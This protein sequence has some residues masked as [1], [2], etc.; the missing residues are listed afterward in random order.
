MLAVHITLYI[1]SMILNRGA[2]L[3]YIRFLKITSVFQG[4]RKALYTYVHVINYVV[5]INARR[6]HK[7]NEHSSSSGTDVVGP[8]TYGPPVHPPWDGWTPRSVHPRVDG[9]PIVGFVLATE[10]LQ[11]NQIAELFIKSIPEP[12]RKPDV[13]FTSCIYTRE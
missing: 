8:P 4:L 7:F 13:M 1:V 6:R 10:I 3:A 9:P 2:C 11:S 12:L 5:L